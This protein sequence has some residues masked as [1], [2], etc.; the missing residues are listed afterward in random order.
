M[1]IV[2]N[3]GHRVEGKS[4][5]GMLLLSDNEGTFFSTGESSHYNGLLHE[6]QYGN[7]E[8]NENGDSDSHRIFKS[9]EEL[10]FETPVTTLHHK[11]SNVEL[12]HK[13][14]N[15]ATFFLRDRVLTCHIVGDGSFFLDMDMRFLDD[16]D[17]EGRVYSLHKEGDI[18]LIIYEKFSGKR[19]AYT[20]T[21]GIK[22]I[23]T[24]E[25]VKEWQERHYKY[26]QRRGDSDK[27]W[28]FRATKITFEKEATLSFVLGATPEEAKR[29]V[30]KVSNSKE[31]LLKRV[32]RSNSDQGIYEDG[33]E[34]DICLSS[35][36][37]LMKEGRIRA[38]FPWFLNVW[39]RDELISLGALVKAGEEATVKS[40]ILSYYKVLEHKELEAFY[41]EGGLR[42]ADALGWLAFRTEQL[43]NLVKSKKSESKFSEEELLFIRKVLEKRVPKSLSLIE[44]GPGETWMD[45]I[46]GE[47][48]RH[49]FRIEIQ[50]GM[51]AFYRL[52]TTLDSKWKRRRDAFIKLV[53]R[54][55]FIKGDLVDGI[56]AEGGIDFTVR[57]NIFIAY[58]LAPEILNRKEWTQVFERAIRRLWLPWGGLAT[59]DKSSPL[60]IGHYTGVDNRSYHRGDSWYWINALAARSMKS[61][62][63]NHFW[64]WIGAL[65]SAC[66]QELLFGRAIGHCSELSSADV[67]SSEG[68]FSQAWSAA[69]LYELL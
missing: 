36:K 67:R 41:P 5:D 48:D 64:P 2:H 25:A 55:F 63:E 15:R 31:E 8:K 1:R 24:Y 20:R 57:P 33:S 65:R 38:G 56:L 60:F 10:S 12:H 22:G 66:L 40:I 26:D 52:L 47:D 7:S 69:M 34:K 6:D 53:K 39:S 43:L 68:T 21:L 58:E 42:S 11:G 19:R 17:S 59:I 35:V 29:L 61:L 18:L 14:G 49:G 32:E 9:I 50:A 13:D 54:R 46:I 27:R 3:I 45:T 51:V 23:K 4:E 30:E 62:N 16:E 28:V 44:N 37:S